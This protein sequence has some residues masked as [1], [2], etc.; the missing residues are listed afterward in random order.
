MNSPPYKWTTTRALELLKNDSISVEA[1]A[2]SL[3]GRIQER[4]RATKAWAYLGKSLKEMEETIVHLNH[5]AHGEQDPELVLS[6][7]RLLDNVPIAERGPLHGL[8][9][10]IKDMMATK[11]TPTEYGSRIYGGHQ[12]S[13]DSHAVSI[14]R[15]AGALI[16]GS[17]HTQITFP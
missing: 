16:F 6:Q 12:P 13:A 4:D 11:D 9:V 2:Q 3:L 7:A 14:L 5:M 1:Y 10:G 17:Q 8:A 15:A